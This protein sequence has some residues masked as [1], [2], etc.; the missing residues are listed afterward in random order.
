MNP[1]Y[2]TQTT[3][4]IPELCRGLYSSAGIEIGRLPTGEVWP[5]NTEFVTDPDGFEY[6][7]MTAG[8]NLYRIKLK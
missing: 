4:G 6:L 3:A 1:E 2:Q 7:Y 8:A 5:T